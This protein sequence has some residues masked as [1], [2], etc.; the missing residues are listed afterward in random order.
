MNAIASRRRV[1]GEGTVYFHKGRNQWVAQQT[2]AGRRI[3]AYGRSAAE[4]RR[5]LQAKLEQ[6][7]GTV[8]S[9]MT[10]ESYLRRWI[11]W[12]QERGELR[13]ES[14]TNYAQLLR[15]YVIP[16]LGGVKL[17]ELGT[18]HVDALFTELIRR[19]L[20]PATIRR[21]RSVLGQALRQAVVWGVL[22]ANPVEPTRTPPVRRKEPDVWTPEETRKFFDAIRGDWLYPLF[23]TAVT[24]GMRLEE[25]IALQWQD[26]DLE[27][28]TITV[29]RALSFN[30]QVKPPK[31]P[32]SN[33]T[34][35][36][37][38]DT[39]AILREHKPPEA[40]PEDWVFT[41]RAG[42]PWSQANLWE[43][44]RTRCTWAGI[45]PIPPKNLRHLHA[46]LL[47]R[48][49]AD[50]ATI[51]KRLGHTGLQVAARHYIRITEDADRKGAI[52]LDDLLA[53]A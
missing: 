34:I 7:V 13:H 33:R 28:G 9:D 2:V 51:A 25:L 4:A 53:D 17:Q 5:K 49:G 40:K 16:Y 41:N 43:A 12:R 37:P 3:T 29:R 14:I 32:A 44:F 27:A 46:T 21:V 45:R 26:I 47:L 10:L 19:K 30:R 18:A 48:A 24:T 8:H 11:A 22:R 36:I 15:L 1:P 31:T 50:L 20:S 42:R 35:A 6:N 38:P 39:V 23:Y 52:P